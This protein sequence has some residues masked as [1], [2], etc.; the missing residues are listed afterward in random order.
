MT[1]KA[2]VGSWRRYERT[3]VVGVS[4]EEDYKDGRR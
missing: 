1:P 2:C 4:K 3:M